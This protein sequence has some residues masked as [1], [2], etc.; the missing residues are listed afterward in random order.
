MEN[1]PSALTIA[2]GAVFVLKVSV[3]ISASGRFTIVVDPPPSGSFL[4]YSNLRHEILKAAADVM[5]LLL[6]LLSCNQ[7]SVTTVFG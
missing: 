6:S 2:R 3:F 5:P 4:P 1:T 7:V